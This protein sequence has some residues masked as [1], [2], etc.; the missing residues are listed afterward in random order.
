MKL[1]R[2]LHEITKDLINEAIVKST[3]DEH[4]FI[5]IE[6][7]NSDFKKTKKITPA[8]LTFLNY[9]LYNK[10]EIFTEIK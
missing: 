6:A 1:N 5:Q 7:I 10:E 9:F 8:Q 2:Q 4:M 3:Y